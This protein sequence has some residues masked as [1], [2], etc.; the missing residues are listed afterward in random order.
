MKKNAG[1]DFFS[2]TNDISNIM[3]N[4][5]FMNK[6]C[7][8]LGR[9]ECNLLF[10]MLK[11]D[12][13]VNMKELADFL[14]VTHSRITHLMDSLIKKGFIDR[15]ASSEDRRMY[16]ALIT[17]EGRDIVNKHIK[18][19]VKMYNTIL[20]QISDDNLTGIYDALNTWKEFL[21]ELL[22]EM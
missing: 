4:F 11:A 13:Q 16:Y 10:Y 1:Q 18:E 3:Y 14:N 9:V 17:E 5:D 8:Q 20:A 6:K 21:Q 7:T 15:I 2:L 19:S 22:N 12:K